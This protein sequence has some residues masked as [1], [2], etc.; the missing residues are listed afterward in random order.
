M[1]RRYRRAFSGHHSR[2]AARTGGGTRGH[3]CD[4][5]H[6]RHA[7]VHPVAAVDRSAAAGPSGRAEPACVSGSSGCQPGGDSFAGHEEEAVTVHSL[8]GGLWEGSDRLYDA[9]AGALASAEARFDLAEDDVG[10]V[11]HGGDEEVGLGGRELV[12]VVGAA[13][14]EADGPDACVVA[15]LHACG[16]V[17]DL[18]DGF[19]GDDLAGE[20]VGAEHAVIDHEG[21]G[22]AGH[23]LGVGY[24]VEAHAKLVL[25]DLGEGQ[26]VFFEVAG[27]A[28]DQ[29]AGGAHLFEGLDG[30]LDGAG[31][32]FVNDVFAHQGTEGGEYRIVVVLVPGTAVLGLPLGADVGVVHEHAQVGGLE[33]AHRLADGGPVAL[34]TEGAECLVEGD[35]GGFA[36]AQV[37]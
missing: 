18:D 25:K 15:A 29:D 23:F 28:A 12:V 16:G 34:D 14:V 21:A 35:D 7:E 26:G 36:A 32:V 13:G 30:A 37:V 20:L 4:S 8:F 17:I 31:E 27:V 3:K 6:R 11:F 5:E 2:T 22:A 19:A 9:L 10:H 1:I 33:C 24:D